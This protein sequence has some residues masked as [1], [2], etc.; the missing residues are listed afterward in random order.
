MKKLPPTGVDTGFKAPAD[1]GQAN[2][3]TARP[4]VE[5]KHQ[6]K[7]HKVR[8]TLPVH[9]VQ[10]TVEPSSIG[11]LQEH[12]FSGRDRL[13]ASFYGTLTM[14]AAGPS[15]EG[16]AELN[17]GRFARDLG[18][19]PFKAKQLVLDLVAVMGG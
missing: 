7:T 14:V 3:T 11:S 4:K 12:V 19:P 6:A 8:S 9:D 17:T 5:G 18:L 15:S 2:Q 13:G 1:V 10:E 16:I